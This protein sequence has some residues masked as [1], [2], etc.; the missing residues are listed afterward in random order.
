MQV[1]PAGT[2]LSPLAAASAAAVVRIIA[3]NLAG[4]PVGQLIPA[5]VVNVSDGS[6]T[7]EVQGQL[8]TVRPAG[9]L[10][11]GTALAAR[12]PNGAAPAIELTAR[13]AP[14]APNA[15]PIAVP[16][17]VLV[18]VLSIQP[19]GRS[20]VRIDNGETALA[21]GEGLAL[22]GRFVMQIEQTPTGLVLRPPTDSPGL[23]KIVASAV[24]R[25][26]RPPDLGAA[27]APLLAELTAVQHADSRISTAMRDAAEA[28]REVV[29][30]FVDSNGRPPEDAQLKKLVDDGGLHYEAKLAR[31]EPRDIDP[32]LAR[33]DLKGA[34]LQLLAAARDIGSSD[35]L[36]MT[37]VALNGIEAQQAANVLAQA[38]GTPYVLQVPFPD[39]GQWRT[40]N[41]AIEREAGRNTGDERSRGDFRLLM[42]VPL[43]ELG[44]TWIDA[45]LAGDQFRAIIYLDKSEVCDR[46]R[47]QLP[48]LRSELR[49]GSFTEVLLDVRAA[50]ELPAPQRQLSAAMKAGRPD[51]LSVLDVR[52]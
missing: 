29:R 35:A 8:V 30:S 23:P 9:G 6:A 20:L 50:R 2:E 45:G 5:T 28:A 16:R 46:V 52:V 39:G 36:P 15:S 38:D 51:S 17:V 32:S 14:E 40:L 33:S 22:G 48:E 27:L 44:E 42:H 25:A 11:P 31:Q 26:A 37:Q 18:D 3:G 47:Q 1:T 10:Q 12:I 34:L 43:T 19:D 49:T 13:G 21:S 4:I 41:L 24:L 7:L